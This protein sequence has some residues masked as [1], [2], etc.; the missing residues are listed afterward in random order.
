MRSRSGTRLCALVAIVTSA[1]GPEGVGP[2]APDPGAEAVP[3]SLSAAEA[4]PEGADAYFRTVLERTN[5]VLAERGTDHRAVAI[6]YLVGSGGEAQGRQVFFRD[7]GNKQLVSTFDGVTF[8]PVHFAPGDVRRAW[9]ADGGNAITYAVDQVDPEVVSGLAI[10]ATTAAIDAA[11]A[12]WDAERCTKGLS[13]VENP[14]FGLDI[15]VLAFGNGLGG[16]PFVFADIHHAG[17]E[18]G[19]PA[20]GPGVVVIAFTTTFAFVDGDGNLTDVDGDGKVD[21]AFREVYYNRDLGFG[22][23]TALPFDVQ[24]VAAHEAGHGLSQAHFGELFQTTRNG[25]FHFSPRALM[26]AGYTGVQ[27]SLSGSDRS[28]HCSIWGRWLGR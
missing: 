16:S 14:D 25:L 27:Q 22:I 13:I 20:P 23:D 21:A 8:V 28:G 5:A 6:E 12:T 1:C 19:I 7:R 11:M 4:G 15:G 24:T 18:F 17:W 2:A 26:N 10:G 9:S 3:P